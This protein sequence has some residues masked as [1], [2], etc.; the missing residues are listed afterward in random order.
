LTSQFHGPQNL[1]WL[2][3]SW[4]LTN[5]VWKREDCFQKVQNYLANPCKSLEWRLVFPEVSWFDRNLSGC[6]ASCDT[7]FFSVF[8]YL[9]FL[10]DLSTT[11][12]VVGLP[13]TFLGQFPGDPAGR[14]ITC[15][16][17]HLLEMPDVPVSKIWLLWFY[18]YTSLP[19]E[20]DVISLS[21]FFSLFSQIQERAHKSVDLKWSPNVH[22]EAHSFVGCSCQGDSMEWCRVQ[23]VPHFEECSAGVTEVWLHSLGTALNIS[24]MFNNCCWSELAIMGRAIT[25]WAICHMKRMSVIV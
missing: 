6:W 5:L 15:S 8:R 14:V 18:E 3:G 20:P 13:T 2:T 22:S 10:F 1:S 9:F 25:W 7:F 24:Y 21:F 12:W 19:C 4:W 17:S 16:G 23:L 11:S